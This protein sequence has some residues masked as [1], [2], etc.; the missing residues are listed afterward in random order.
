MCRPRL[1]SGFS[2]VEVLTVIAILGAL[3]AVT[4]P[5]LQAGRSGARRTTCLNNLR[6]IGL[7]MLAHHEALSTFPPGGIEWRPPSDSS[8]RQLAWSA[9]LLP[10]LDEQPLHDQID[11]NRP[12]DAP[13]NAQPAAAILPVY[14]C[15]TSVRGAVL[16]ES[17][18]PCDYGAIYGERITGPN[19][20]A[21]GLMI[22]DRP[23][24]LRDAVDGASKT[25]LV[26]EDT[27]WNEGQW[28]NGRNVFD[29]AYAV[30]SAPPFENDL[31]SDHPGG[32][33]G[34][35]ADAAVRWMADDTDLKLL[36]SFCTRAGH[37]PLP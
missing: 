12:F 16:V 29:Q 11:F 22:Y 6:Q 7:A 8:K 27:H 23:L 15:P 4:L 25:L 20:P 37:D 3:C 33:F 14:V 18:G 30:N 1:S 26:G 24:A 2:L 31:R 35:L 28:I 17:R 34:V 32:A 9:L 10:F 21:K 13:E 36:A 5:A 19:R